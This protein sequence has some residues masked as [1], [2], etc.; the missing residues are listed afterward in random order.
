MLDN[1]G[2]LGMPQFA[3]PIWREPENW[4][5]KKDFALSFVSSIWKFGGVREWCVL[6][7][8][9]RLWIKQNGAWPAKQIV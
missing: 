9:E 5:S 8:R 4:D 2:N 6:P 3:Q 7:I 1:F